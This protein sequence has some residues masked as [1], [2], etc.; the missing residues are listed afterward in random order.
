MKVLIV[1]DEKHVRTV[2]RKL[3]DW[4]T[5]GI[6]TVL[7]AEDGADAIQIIRGEQPQ[8]VITDIMMPVKSGV[9]L[10]EWMEVHAPDCKKIVISGHNDFEYVRHTVK[11][12]GIDYLLKPIDKKQL[13]EAVG[14][15]AHS[16]NET[17]QERLQNQ[18]RNLEVNE[19]K[20]IYRDKLLSGLLAE[21]STSGSSTLRE[22]LSREFPELRDTRSCR[23]AILDLELL[24]RAI[25]E[26][27][28]TSMDLLEFSLINICND[29]LRVHRK[30][31][32]FRNWNKPCEIVMLVWN[33]VG[34]VSKIMLEIHEGIARTL[35]TR[36]DIG[37][38]SE[39]SFPNGLQEAY[40]QALGALRQR[41][42]FNPSTHIHEYRAVSSQRISSLRFG[43]YEDAIQLAVKSGQPELIRN[44]LQQWFDVIY[45]LDSLTIELLEMWWVEYNVTKAHWMEEFFH[46]CHDDALHLPPESA[47]FVVPLD[48]DGNLS[49]SLLQQ[50]L[51]NSLIALSQLL[52]IRQTPTNAMHEIARYLEMNYNQDISLMDISTRFHLN[53]EYISRRFKQEFQETIVDF[54]SRIRVEKAKILLL[55]PYFKISEIAQTVGYQDEKYFSRVFKKIEGK[56]PKDFRN[57]D[58]SP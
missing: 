31:I 25:R 48:D 50:E 52:V 2:V 17:E 32:A 18:Q 39:L 28:A 1:D 49:L 36:I 26:K 54:V 20:P 38:G 8:L 4:G 33:D 46:N 53:R 47:H 58:A 43:K 9:E 22:P 12:G 29:F 57:G 24:E 14:K 11:Y 6:D 55:N 21:F 41:N 27:F 34:A 5:Y 23:V 19:L 10:M 45:A 51:T 42:L 15:A 13:Q 44:T 30:G 35:G 3:I 56:P 40:L 37:I 7:E 16:W